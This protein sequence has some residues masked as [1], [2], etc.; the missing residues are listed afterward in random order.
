MGKQVFLNDQTKFCSKEPHFSQLKTRFAL[1]QDITEEL[2]CL[3]RIDLSVHER[4]VTSE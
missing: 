4:K 1:N 3:D 2:G